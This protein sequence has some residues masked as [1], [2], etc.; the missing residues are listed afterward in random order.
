MDGSWFQNQHSAVKYLIACAAKV[1]QEMRQD[2]SNTSHAEADTDTEVDTLV[3]LTS[4]DIF[5]STFSCA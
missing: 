1:S 2:Q 4:E 5:F 3:S